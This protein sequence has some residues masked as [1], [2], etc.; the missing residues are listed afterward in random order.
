MTTTANVVPI[1]LLSLPRSGST[2]LQRILASHAE[3]STSPEPTFLLPLLHLDRSTDTLATFDQRYT[4]W[5]VQDFIASL[6]DGYQT[7]RREVACFALGLYRAA[8]DDGV[9]YHLD[10]T[11]KYHL[12]AE[13]LVDLFPE[14][15]VIVLWRNPLSVIASIITTWGAGAGRWNL[16]DFRVDL[17]EGIVNLVHLVERR[18]DRVIQ[19]RYEDLVAEPI[20]TLT[21]LFA[22]LG[23]EFDPGV[24]ER[25]A[26]LQLEGRVQDPNVT[27]S[28]F[29]TLR[30]DRTEQWKTVLANPFRRRWARRYLRWL[31]SD[32]LAVMGYDLDLLVDAIDELPTS[33]EF[34]ASDLIDMPADP[35]RRLVEFPLLAMKLRD[36]RAGRPLLA[37][38]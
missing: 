27:S 10:K 23:L 9:R 31:G 7:Y 25:F 33:A 26:D 16:G 36:F 30:S 37:H 22:A 3:V 13:E 1:F 4:S 38:K 5:A 8:A 2:L 24:L 15:P 12:I 11:P 28:G 6:P 32:R 17:Y 20:A 35:I 18:S 21:A 34:L 19:V 14:S 29:E